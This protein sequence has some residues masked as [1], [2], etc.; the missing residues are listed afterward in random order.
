MAGGGS[1]GADQVLATVRTEALWPDQV[2]AADG[3]RDAHG[4]NREC[5][6]SPTLPTRVRPGR[7]LRVA[8]R[9]AARTGRARSSRRG[10]RVSRGRRV[11]SGPGS[12]P[13]PPRLPVR[14]RRVLR[15]R[16]DDAQVGLDPAFRVQEQGVGAE[17]LFRRN[18]VRQDGV[19]HPDGVFA[20]E[21]E[22]SPSGRS[23]TAAPFC[24]AAWPRRSFGSCVV[25]GNSQIFIGPYSKAREEILW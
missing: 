7:G 10:L 19:Q 15:R 21:T 25:L 3:Y 9:P 11:R 8:P 18:V 17:V 14:C 22:D 6:R 4:E 13:P 1:A 23:T 24:R 2:V 16:L 5:R 12:P 20:C